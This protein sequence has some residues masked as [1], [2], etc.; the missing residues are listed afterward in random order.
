[1]FPKALF[2]RVMKTLICVVKEWDSTRKKDKTK[3]SLVLLINIG[4]ALKIIIMKYDIDEDN[5]GV[6]H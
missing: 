1:M 4:H 5:K 6:I 2:L 3:S